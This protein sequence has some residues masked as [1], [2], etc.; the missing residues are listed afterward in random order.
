MRE[1]KLFVFLMLVLGYV[2]L[3]PLVAFAQVVA[4]GSDGV[5]TTPSESS[6]LTQFAFAA[7]VALKLEK[8]KNSATFKWLTPYAD[9]ITKL[10]ALAAGLL[11]AVGITWAF[12]RDAAGY[13]TLVFSNIPVTWD[14]V[15]AVAKTTFEQYWATKMFYLTAVKPNTAAGR[16]V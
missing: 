7:Y 3:S 11:T 1:K 2:A 8:L 13:G 4:G 14:T 9:H 15:W 6:L 12:E 16:S 5:M 10:W